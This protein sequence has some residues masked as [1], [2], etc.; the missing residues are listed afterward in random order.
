MATD[1]GTRR[2][3]F[4]DTHLI[5]SLEGAALRLHEP[6]PAGKVFAPDAPWEG[7][8]NGYYT[9]LQDGGEFRMYYR[10][11]PPTQR[12]VK[13]P[14][15]GAV[16]RTCLAVSS[17]GVRWTRPDLGLYEV[18]GARR[19]N[20]ILADDP[21]LSTN[22]APFLD[23]NPSAP[24]E[25]RYKAV[26]GMGDKMLIFRRGLQ[27][28]E[29][30]GLFAFT[31]PDGIHWRRGERRIFMDGTRCFDSHNVAHWS[32]AEG[33]YVLYYRQHTLRDTPEFVTADGHEYFHAKTVCRATSP[34]F[35]RWSGREVID[36]D[37]HP[38]TPQECIYYTGA[39]PYPRAPHITVCLA[40]RFM[41]RRSA[42][43][44]AQ[45]LPMA[46]ELDAAGRWC[47]NFRESGK[48]WL[49]DDCTDTV[50]MTA[51]AGARFDRTFMEGFIRPGPGARNWTSR[52]NMAARGVLQTGPEELSLY[53]VRQYGQMT[54]HLERMT[55]RLDGF[56]SLHAPYRGGGMTTKPLTFAGRRLTLNCA[57]S[58]AG[59]VRVEITDPAGAPIRGHALGDCAEIIG[60]D[61]ARVVRWTGAE[62]L[63]AL[64][65]K[66]VRLRFEMK[67]ADIYSIQFGM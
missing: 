46:E 64:A 40:M 17:D 36:F 21:P 23:T 8:H 63:S 47:G 58:A 22:F 38:P 51:R 60:D 10:A 30:A 44:D 4:V 34:D 42:L 65:G 55:L 1:I 20:V 56:A 53:V 35:Q 26:A 41:Q 43:A 67:D 11:F 62:D 33:R 52:S 66:P 18:C 45:V 50:L 28:V 31:S 15:D 19:N 2:E 27:P 57:T 24:P 54:H 61:T 6:K 32:V 37:G 59:W 29:K 7:E 25:E 39:M 49:S 9:V 12:G 16:E 5:D 48:F 3:L 14:Y 13:F